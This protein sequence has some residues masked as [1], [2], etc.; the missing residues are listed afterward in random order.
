MAKKNAT[1]FFKVDLLREAVR[2]ETNGKEAI[3]AFS[4]WTLANT[5]LRLRVSLR[6]FCFKKGMMAI[7]MVTKTSRAGK[8]CSEKGKNKNTHTT[9]LLYAKT[10]KMRGGRERDENGNRKSK[11]EECMTHRSKGGLISNHSRSSL[12][13]LSKSFGGGRVAC[14]L[15]N[16]E[17]SS[18]RRRCQH[19]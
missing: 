15:S 19:G 7:S 14:S 2:V 10:L 11:K 8:A 16:E 9:L 6:N 13:L 17:Q 3:P 18:H 5:S 12:S 4:R 1:S